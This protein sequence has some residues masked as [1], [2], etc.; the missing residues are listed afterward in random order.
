MKKKIPFELLS[1]FEPIIQSNYDIIIN[2]KEENTYY[3]LRDREIGSNFFFKIF[4]DGSKRIS[5]PDKSKYTFEFQPINEA[6]TSHT[7]NQ[8]KVEDVLVGL[9]VWI[10]ILKKYNE[11]I[12]VHDDNF[13]KA[14]SEF[15][16][17]EFKI[18]DTDANLYPFTP[19][20]QILLEK[21]LDIIEPIITDTKEI[22]NEA[23]IA[24]IKDEINHLRDNLT[25]TTKNQVIQKLSRIWAKVFKYSKK[26]AK[27][28]IDKAIET[29][30]KQMVEQGIKY[31]PTIIDNLHST[32][33]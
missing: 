29:F 14:Y 26:L 31:L 27:I 28:A 5:N 30:V 6:K 4:I 12:S 3:L 13:L 23:V 25:T 7:L 18:V 24:E 21:Y 1:R 10:E 9:N 11:T 32:P 19:P 8:G 20:Q 17:S 2:V 15:Y 22:K 16:F 33:K